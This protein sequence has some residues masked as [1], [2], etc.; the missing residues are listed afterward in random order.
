[1]E[2]PQYAHA[3]SAP[4]K[5]PSEGGAAAPTVPFNAGRVFL[6]TGMFMLGTLVMIPVWNSVA[7]AVG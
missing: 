7:V 3:Y 2:P 6:L 4:V 5:V 1:M